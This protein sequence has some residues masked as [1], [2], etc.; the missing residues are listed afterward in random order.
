[1]VS[2]RKLM[3][4]SN[5]SGP[6]GAV[7]FM[8]DAAKEISSLWD[9]AVVPVLDVG[10]TANDLVLMAEVP[11]ND[12]RLGNRYRFTPEMAN[13]GAVTLVI[14]PL[15]SPVQLK[16]RSGAPLASGRLQPGVSED[17]VYDGGAFLLC[18]DGV[19]VA[20]YQETIMAYETPNGASSI[21][22]PAG[23][24]TWPINTVVKN[25]IQLAAPQNGLIVLPPSTYDVTAIFPAFTIN[26]SMFVIYDASLDI[27]FPQLR[28]GGSVGYGSRTSQCKIVLQAPKSIS[29]RVWAD[30][31]WGAIPA[32]GAPGL[33]EQRGGLII[34]KIA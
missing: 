32:L 2:N 6:I 13:T 3:A 30:V 5:T 29:L 14:P 11:P 28:G 16:S 34:R 7:P 22:V 9:Y 18:A 15:I 10:G 26:Q 31:A 27:V 1:M 19:L 4:P 21:A 24:S 23:W 12:L 33:T 20:A 25:E 8:E 17:C